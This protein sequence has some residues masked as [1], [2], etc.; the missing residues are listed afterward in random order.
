MPDD[1][2]DAPEDETPGQRRARLM[3]LNNPGWH[4]DK[5]D[6]VDEV[7]PPETSAIEDDPKEK[8]PAE[9]KVEAASEAKPRPSRER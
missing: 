3:N 1:P 2:H 8:A 9:V 6:K 5:V 7:P 4:P